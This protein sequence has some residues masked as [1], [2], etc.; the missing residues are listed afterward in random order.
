MPEDALSLDTTVDP[1]VA[2]GVRRRDDA[3]FVL[4]SGRVERGRSAQLGELL[5]LLLAVLGRRVDRG[6]AVG[7]DV[8]SDARAAFLLCGRRHTRR[9]LGGRRAG[10]DGMMNKWLSEEILQTPRGVS[11]SRLPVPLSLY[12]V[13]FDLFDELSCKGEREG[14]MMK[15]TRARPACGGPPAHLLSTSRVCWKSRYSN[16]CKDENTSYSALRYAST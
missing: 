6:L 10:S 3:R 8:L 9:R 14:R 12:D 16:Q 11:Y 13:P 7:A 15:S 4:E 2:I 5:G 1:P